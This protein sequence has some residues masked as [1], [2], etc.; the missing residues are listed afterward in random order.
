MQSQIKPCDLFI[1]ALEDSIVIQRAKES[2]S[3]IDTKKIIKR[4][5][6][7]QKRVI[8]LM[9]APAIERYEHFIQ[10]YPDIVQRV[11]QKNDRILSRNHTTGT[12]Y[13]KSRNRG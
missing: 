7:L 5:G 4:L 2:D 10:T 13:T 3:E 6:V 12:E 1:D 8:M 11:P 9:S